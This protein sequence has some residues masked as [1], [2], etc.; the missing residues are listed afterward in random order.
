[1]AL[2]LG[3]D[4]PGETNHLAKPA[5]ALVDRSR[6][7]GPLD[8]GLRAHMMFAFRLG[9]GGK[10]SQKIALGFKCESARTAHGEVRLHSL[11]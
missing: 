6:Q 7:S 8:G 1:M 11:S 5:G 9:E 2:I 10:T 4:I 3:T